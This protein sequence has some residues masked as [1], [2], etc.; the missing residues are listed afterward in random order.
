VPDTPQARDYHHA[1]IATELQG[2]DAERQARI[3]HAGFDDDGASGPRRQTECTRTKITEREPRAV[4]GDDDREQGQQTRI[5]QR[6]IA[7]KTHDDKGEQRD[8]ACLCERS[9]QA[10]SEG[11]RPMGERDAGEASVRRARRAN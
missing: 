1:E 11:W 10:R 6:S 9:A 4:L 5:E 3:L 7:I 2:D 8:E